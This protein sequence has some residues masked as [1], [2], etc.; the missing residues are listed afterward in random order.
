M[1]FKMPIFL[2]KYNLFCVCNEP[3]EMK[4]D[5]KANKFIIVKKTNVI[6]SAK[7]F[8]YLR[9]LFNALLPIKA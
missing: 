3:N 6:C 5:K 9:V 7:Y 8:L 1:S 4:P 2:L